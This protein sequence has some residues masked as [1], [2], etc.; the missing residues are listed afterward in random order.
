MRRGR[1]GGREQGGGKGPPS[2]PEVAQG[3]VRRRLVRPGLVEAA[4]GRGERR[5]RQ[6]P[7]GFHKREVGQTSGCSNAWLAEG[8]VIARATELGLAETAGPGTTCLSVST[9]AACDE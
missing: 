6:K 4:S 3:I 5:V 9:E 8:S 1:A 2:V 7:K